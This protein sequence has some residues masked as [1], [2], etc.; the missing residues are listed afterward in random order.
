MYHP[1][2]GSTSEHGDAS[3]ARDPR[4]RKT[5][6]VVGLCVLGALAVSGALRGN[7]A[8]GEPS[9]GMATSPA[10]PNADDT[11]TARALPAIVFVSRLAAPPDSGQIPGFGPH[12]RALITAGRLMIR[13][14]DGEVRALPG[15]DSLFDVSHPAISPDAKRLAF[16]GVRSRTDH[17]RVFVTGVNGGAIRQVTFAPRAGELEADDLEPCWIDERTLCFASTRYA[18]RSEYVDVP[19]T[20]LFACD[21]LTGR[22][23]RLTSERNGAETPSVDAERGRLLF[24][25]W[26]F[27]RYRSSVD[28]GVTVAVER[29][30]PGDSVN[31]WQAM[32]MESGSGRLRMACGYPVIRVEAMGVQ[33]IALGDGSFAAVYARNLGLSP[34]PGGTGIWIFRGAH[35][36]PMRLAGVAVPETQLDPYTAASGL[37]APSACDPAALPDG[38]ILFAFDPG[39]RG[40]FG[41]WIAAA[42]G[43]T[44]SCL[45]DLPGTLELDPAPVV[46]RAGPT[47][48]LIFPAAGADGDLA[49][50]R[51]ADLRTRRTFTFHD[52]DVF[53]I[54]RG[55]SGIGTPPPATRGAR[56]EVYAALDAPHAPGG[57][58]L[59]RIRDVP[60]GTHGEV[61]ID[62]LPAD[63]P[64]FEQLVDASGRAVM[65]AHGPAQVRGFNV[66]NSRA[67]STCVGCHV[68]HSL[69]PAVP[70]EPVKR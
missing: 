43:E 7:A 30:M 17:W 12:G 54:G 16:A 50:A 41:I 66:G 51:L 34:R 58:T 47:R 10:L 39:A 22:I 48:A 40:D 61:R 24:S 5:A 42:D 11:L 45:V 31:V 60:I 68:G 32:E 18:Q 28:G 3:A 33:P 64:L 57:D 26:W 70:R 59:V 63:T 14:A 62:G 55:D 49:H 9:Q 67:P 37:A 1:R 46:A 38:R 65:G 15:T 29:V 52:L 25:R 56:L 21:L 53:A 35:T 23:T 44:R 2:M 4:R 36:R 6:P 27:N 8:P 13:D 69:L 19:V 20:N